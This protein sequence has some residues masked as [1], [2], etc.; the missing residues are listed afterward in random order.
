MR[1][2]TLLLMTLFALVPPGFCL[3]RLT[4]AVMPEQAH[5]DD[6]QDHNE[7]DHEDTDC[8]CPQLLPDY[9]AP[10][11]DLA[12]PAPVITLFLLPETGARVGSSTLLASP[13]FLDDSAPPLYLALRALRL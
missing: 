5:Q 4:A 8:D 10:G 7:D 9:T 11:Y 13:P 2:A 12:D 1:L 3:C 6:P